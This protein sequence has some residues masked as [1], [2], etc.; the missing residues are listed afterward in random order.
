MLCDIIAYLSMNYFILFV[1]VII[2]CKKPNNTFDEIQ[3]LTYTDSS[4][5][6]LFISNDS[7][8]IIQYSRGKCEN[9]LGCEYGPRYYAEVARYKNIF[10]YINK[11]SQIILSDSFQLERMVITHTTKSKI[12]YLMKDSLIKEYNYYGSEKGCENINKVQK[13]I[14]EV[15]SKADRNNIDI[16]E[17]LFDVSGLKYVD[18][19]RIIKLKSVIL[20]GSLG[21]YT[22][23]IKDYT[24][25]TINNKVRIDSFINCLQNQIILDTTE[26]KLFGNFIPKYDIDFFKKGLIKF[27]LKTDL[28]IIPYFYP[29]TLKVD[30]CFVKQIQ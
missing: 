27:Q 11:E 20:D 5:I 28:K 22:N 17:H 10:P 19:I 13:F 8:L 15:I 1:L 21:K 24:L 25:V 4:L 12:K 6:N 29:Q 3:I 16:K 7:T 14:F 18:S 30:S 26:S 9:Y 23:F 2:G